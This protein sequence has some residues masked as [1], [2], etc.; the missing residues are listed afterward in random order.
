MSDESTP[1]AVAGPTMEGGYLAAMGPVRGESTPAA[2]LDRLGA[3]AIYGDAPDGAAVCPFERGIV[4][5]V[6]AGVTPA[7]ET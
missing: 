2:S 4:W 3:H 7:A 5:V 6:E 1:S